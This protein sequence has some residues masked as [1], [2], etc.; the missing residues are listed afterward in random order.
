MSLIML[1]GMLH[2]LTGLLCYCYE[3]LMAGLACLNVLEYPVPG[4]LNCSKTPE[5]TRTYRNP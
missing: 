3:N 5:M 1:R 4:F 2:K